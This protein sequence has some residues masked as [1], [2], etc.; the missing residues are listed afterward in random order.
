VSEGTSPVEVL[1]RA[2][3]R[4]VAERVFG[5]RAL[6]RLYGA[7]PWRWLAPLAA[8][9]AVSRLYGLPQ[10]G[11]RSRARVAAFVRDLGIDA[12]EAERP[13]DAYRSLDDFF[14]RRL[15]PGARPVEPD[16]AR[17]AA[18]CDGRALAFPRLDGLR[19]PVKGA[20]VEVAELLGDAALASAYH[21]GAALVVRLAPA[22]YHRV[23]FP[24]GG[25]AG[26]ARRLP[27]PLHSVHP[28]ALTAG[29]PAFRNR[30][31]ISLLE[32]QVFGRLALVEVG[33]LLV[34]RIAQIYRP[35]PV[36]RG[37]E[38]ALFRLGGSTVVLL[39]ERG[40]VAW[41][42]DLLAATARG[43]ECLVRAGSGVGR[44]PAGDAVTTRGM[45]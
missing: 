20:R 40:R 26:P 37:G 33:A 32:S 31:E 30:R 15:R 9:P 21:G 13:L 27:G 2:T 41:D 24:D 38:K 29:A 42:A 6:R 35:G 19:L 34:G 28:L 43:L 3:G 5:E 7:G 14:T 4:V 23:H 8:W 39:A 17:L 1:D 25:V 10:Q 36:A 22:D 11:A 18:P 12:G 16:P 44:R 45:A